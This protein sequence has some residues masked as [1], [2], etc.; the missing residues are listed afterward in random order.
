MS[1]F[2]SPHHYSVVRRLWVSQSTSLFHSFFP[3]HMRATTMPVS[4]G[5]YKILANV[6]VELRAAHSSS[7]YIY[8]LYLH[9]HILRASNV[10]FLVLGPHEVTRSDT[11]MQARKKCLRIWETDHQTTTFVECYEFNNF[12]LIIWTKQTFL[13]GRH[14]DGQQTHEKMLN[15]THYQRNANQNHNEVPLHTSQNGC[16]PKVYKQ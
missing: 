11:E 5:C 3:H 7:T 10:D 15:I 2:R 13:Q 4:W 8:H 6:H 14:T 9:L 16:Y 12:F 1:G